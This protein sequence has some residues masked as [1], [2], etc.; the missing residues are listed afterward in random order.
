MCVNVVASGSENTDRNN[1]RILCMP[2]CTPG[3]NYQKKT[4]AFRVNCAIPM[5]RQL[6][7]PIALFP[8]LVLFPG[9]TTAS[10]REYHVEE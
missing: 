6:K 1:L 10:S 7:H 8:R 9:P 4:N 3:S 5:K 2:E